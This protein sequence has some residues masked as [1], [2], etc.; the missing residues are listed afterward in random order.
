MTKPSSDIAKACD[1]M[2]RRLPSVPMRNW[3]GFVDGGPE[4]VRSAWLSGQI[5][6]AL[7]R[8]WY[9]DLDHER[10]RLK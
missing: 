6:E 4:L 8:R 5:E 3:I 9:P 7:F 2:Y 10:R 1:E